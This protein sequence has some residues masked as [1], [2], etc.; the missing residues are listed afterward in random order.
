MPR[1]PAAQTTKIHI[2]PTIATPA[3]LFQKA[4]INTMLMPP[5]SS[6]R[7]IV[8]ARCSL[9]AWP[10]WRALHVETARTLAAFIFEDLLCQWGAVE[11]IVTDNGSAFVAALDLLADRYGIHHIRISAYNSCT[12]G[13]VEQQHRTI[14][15]S[16][17]KVCKGNIARWPSTAPHAFWADRVTT[18]KSTG[19]T[20]F[21]MA[22]SVEPILPFDITLA[23]FLVPDLSTPL[24][25][26]ELLAICTHQLQKHES[27]LAAIHSN[28]LQSHFASVEQ[29][30]HTYEKAIR[31][32]NFRPGTLVLVC[33]ST[34]KTTFSRKF[35]P[36]YFG[37]MVIICKTQ[38]GTYRLV[39]LD[40]TIS[41]L[42]F[43]AFHLVPYHSH[44]HTTIPVT[45][46]V[47]RKVLMCIYLDK[48]TVDASSDSQDKDL[49]SF[50]P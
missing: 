43:M 41:K 34:I 37:P 1:A 20:P 12:N 13:V 45:C 38:M 47:E 15:E 22:H 25:T 29:F 35:Q 26:E 8:Q 2:P 40:S 39:E 9:T 28:I 30:K 44:S 33:N 23:T 3:P 11:E 32:S 17:V 48:D 18:H 49:S 6:F 4:Y 46:L 31:D 16:I 7:Y 36:R 24:T 19:H 42:R 50:Q 21:Y 27:D 14:R 10:E 5:T